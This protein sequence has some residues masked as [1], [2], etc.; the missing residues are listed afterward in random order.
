MVLELRKIYQ[1]LQVDNVH[2]S[3]FIDPGKCCK[4]SPREL[5]NLFFPSTL[6]S[7]LLNE[8]EV[9]SLVYIWV[10]CP[11]QSHQQLRRLSPGT[12]T[13]RLYHISCDFLCDRGL[14]QVALS[15]SPPKNPCLG[16]LRL[17]SCMYQSVQGLC[18]LFPAPVNSHI[19]GCKLPVQFYPAPYVT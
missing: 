18:S 11:L 14:N 3:A 13:P 8:L 12:C 4:A 15:G 6:P 1:D 7:A 16:D 5:C 19:S 10:C 2:L 9:L 17:D